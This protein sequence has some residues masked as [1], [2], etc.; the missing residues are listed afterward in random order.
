MDE[1]CGEMI[2]A[3]DIPDCPIA[4]ECIIFVL[5]AHDSDDLFD[6]VAV[7]EETADSRLGAAQKFDDTLLDGCR[8]EIVTAVGGDEVNAALEDAVG[9]SP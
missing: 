1:S 3:G 7:L 6:G 2:V 8:C 5:F 4:D 9:G